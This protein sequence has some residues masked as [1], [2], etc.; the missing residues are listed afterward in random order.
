MYSRRHQACEASANHDHLFML[1]EPSPLSWHR[2][3]QSL[4]KHPLLA[5][6]V[7]AFPVYHQVIANTGQADLVVVPNTLVE[8]NALFPIC[9]ETPDGLNFR[10]T[11]RWRHDHGERLLVQR[12]EGLAAQR[13]TLHPLNQ[14]WKRDCLAAIEVNGSFA[15]FLSGIDTGQVGEFLCSPVIDALR[16]S[17]PVAG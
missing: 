11:A 5:V 15:A 1:H 9:D 7:R 8:I 6:V 14:E 13:V 2:D 12:H 3:H 17:H 10:I 16:E 4:V